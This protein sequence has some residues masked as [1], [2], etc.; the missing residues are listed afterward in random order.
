MVKSVQREVPY[1]G[2]NTF[3]KSTE[4][5]V[6]YITSPCAPQI[7]GLI[8]KI[9]PLIKENLHI[10]LRQMAGVQNHSIASIETAIDQDLRMKP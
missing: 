2:G 8:T 3:F 1:T 5:I 9:L 7:R 4:N 6:Y 10:L